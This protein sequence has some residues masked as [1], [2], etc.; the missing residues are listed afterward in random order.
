VQR[1]NRMRIVCSACI[2][3][4]SDGLRQIYP[5][6]LPLCLLL[7]GG[8]LV[9]TNVATFRFPFWGPPVH[10]PTSLWQVSLPPAPP[11]PGRGHGWRMRCRAQ[12]ALRLHCAWNGTDCDEGRGRKARLELSGGFTPDLFAALFMVPSMVAWTRGL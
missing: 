8:L 9:F 7:S 10:F 5:H 2:S 11:S 1:S 6:L 3:C 4:S 12:W